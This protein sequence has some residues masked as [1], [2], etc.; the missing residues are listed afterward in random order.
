M[1]TDNL[2]INIILDETDVQNPIFVEIENEYGES[3]NIGKR[4]SDGNLT[5]L[6]I[7]VGDILNNKN[8]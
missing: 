7:S 5:K 6:R 2:S 4:E 3:I 1:T 8:I